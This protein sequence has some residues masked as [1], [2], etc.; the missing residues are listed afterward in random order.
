MVAVRGL[1]HP[2]DDELN[3]HVLSAVPRQLPVGWRLV[4]P[5]GK[6]LPI[7]GAIALAMALRVLTAVDDTP[8]EPRPGLRSEQG[9]V[10]T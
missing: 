2:D 1:E 4:K 8:T 5:K 6:N 3:R 10:F 9:V 7:D